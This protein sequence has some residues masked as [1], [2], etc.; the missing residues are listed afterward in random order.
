MKKKPS[1]NI[2]LYKYDFTEIEFNIEDVC[3]YIHSSHKKEGSYIFNPD[4]LHSATSHYFFEHLSLHT[5]PFHEIFF[6]HYGG[7]CIETDEGEINLGA[8]DLV[9]I[10]PH[11]KHLAS[12]IT[13][14]VAAVFNFSYKKNNLK[15]NHSLYELLNSIFSKP[16]VH[17]KKRLPLYKL[18]TGFLTSVDSGNHFMISR[19]F[20]DI[21]IDIIE[22]T[23]NSVIVSPNDLLKDSSVNRY[24]KI[25]TL[26]RFFYTENLSLEFIAN[27]LNLSLK[28]TSRI[29]KDEFG[30]TLQE[31]ILQKR[32]KTAEKLLKDTNMK[33]IDIASAVGYD[34]NMSFYNA[35]K[36]HFGCLP[37]ELRK[38]FK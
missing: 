20:Y 23:G 28:Q 8:D 14:E 25:Q 4:V 31:L 9:I 21:M 1:E 2:K 22:H 30:C 12:P 34:S 27:N 29:I 38:R 32:M 6:T 24:R 11:T 16:Y 15:T 10:S 36:K 17:L 26:I 35:F 3:F 5:H 37:N 18:I 19:Y 7:C 33:I 13:S